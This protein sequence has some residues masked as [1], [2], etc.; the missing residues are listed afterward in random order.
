M[1][2]DRFMGAL[3]THSSIC[4]ITGQLVLGNGAE[5]KL[6]M[7]LTQTFSKDVRVYEDHRLHEMAE[8][9]FTTRKMHHA[10]RKRVVS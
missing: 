8:R 5:L 3:R 6:K 2:C 7:L 9:L 4:F 10:P 1:L